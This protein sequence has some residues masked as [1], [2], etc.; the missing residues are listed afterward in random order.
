MSQVRPHW[1]RSAAL[2]LSSLLALSLGDEARGQAGV[3][4]RENQD[5]TVEFTNVPRAGS[6][7]RERPAPAGRAETAAPPPAAVRTASKGAGA[8]WFRE[9]ADGVVEFTNLH[10]VGGRWKVLFKTG[11]GK[12]ASVRGTTD[13]IPAQDRS[14]ER[15]GRY[16]E[17]IRDQRTLYGIPP[18]L[19]RAVIKT[20]SDF[21]PHVVSSVG[22]MGLMQLMPGT[23]RDMG[24]SDPFD[25]RQNIMGGCR[26][27]QIL[28]RRYCRTRGAGGADVAFH[29]SPEENVKVIS[30]YH[31][32]PGAV[33]KYGGMPPYQTTRTYVA[34]VLSRFEQFLQ[35]EAPE[36][37]VALGA[38]WE[39]SP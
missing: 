24:V 15:Y 31:A 28:A 29:C 26:Y 17:H 5:G 36:D 12:A 3:W 21:D 4:T 7:W 8:F 30:A 19:A 35:K 20:E 10:P 23:A 18:A 13:R 9:R 37:E 27:L 6:G 1:P 34:T 25:P 14:P 38:R 33:D 32:G 16:D 2:V 39:G 11:P 22:A